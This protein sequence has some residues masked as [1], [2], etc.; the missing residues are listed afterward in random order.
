[1]KLSIKSMGVA[2]VIALITLY[3]AC[4]SENKKTHD[5]TESTDRTGPDQTETENPIPSENPTPP[6]EFDINSIPISNQ[7]LGD[8]PFLDVPEG[9]TEQ[10]KPLQRKFDRLFFPIDGTMTPLE[11]SV[12]KSNIV[13]Q[14]DN[15]DEWSLPYFEKSYDEAI[16]AVGGVKIF[17]GE[18]TKEEY[19]RYHSQ[20]PYLGEDGSI[21][22]AGQNIKVYAIHREDG[23]N[24]FIQL[25]GYSAGGY[26]NILQKEH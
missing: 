26:I 6:K 9:L 8:F 16:K 22:Y 24:I 12:W 14:R 15:T 20:A 11:G 2:C 4:N 17:D 25:A 18:I 21:G 1:M 19:D 23:A 10:N 5:N 3:T 7:E 13:M